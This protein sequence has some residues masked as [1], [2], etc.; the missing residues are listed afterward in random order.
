MKTQLLL[1][2]LKLCIMH[3][4]ACKICILRVGVAY[5]DLWASFVTQT[6]QPNL[7]TLIIRRFII[8]IISIIV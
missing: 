3:N 1:V 4:G 8:K 5:F 6:W 7:A 2:I